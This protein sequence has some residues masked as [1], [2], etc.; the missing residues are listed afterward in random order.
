MDNQNLPQR[1][2]RP[3]PQCINIPSRKRKLLPVRLKRVWPVKLNLF[4]DNTYQLV[5]LG[6]PL[7][8]IVGLGWK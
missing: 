6:R 5:K 1:A 4:A 3:R 2:E 7:Y 8:K